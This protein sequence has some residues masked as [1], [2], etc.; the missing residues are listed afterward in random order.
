MFKCGDVVMNKRKIIS[1]LIKIMSI[2]GIILALSYHIVTIAYIHA[3]VS[4]DGLKYTQWFNMSVNLVYM[5]DLILYIL[6]GVLI[7]IW[8][9]AELYCLIGDKK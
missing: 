7:C 8:L 2:I 4:N 6:V 9:L 3:P 5:I 1:F